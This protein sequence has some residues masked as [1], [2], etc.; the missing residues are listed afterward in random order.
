MAL[1]VAGLLIFLGIHTTGIL[2][3]DWRQGMVAK[4]GLQKWKL[5][6]SVLAVVGLA[7]II[8]GYGAARMDPV[9]LWMPPVW[10]RHLAM[11]LTLLAFILLAATYVPGNSIKAKFG[12]PM[13]AAVKVWAI[14]HLLAN[15]SLADLLLFGGFLIWAIVGFAVLRRRDRSNGVVY[16]KGSLKGNIITG[17]AGVLAWAVFAMLLHTMLIGV[18]PLP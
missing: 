16:P 2:A 5:L 6:Y 9:W 17:V 8:I 15:G 10:T 3:S 11:P 7:L 12:H 4:L 14:A 13:L 1:L 18:S